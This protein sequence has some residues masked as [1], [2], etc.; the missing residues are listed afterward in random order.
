M[1]AGEGGQDPAGIDVKSVGHLVLHQS[2]TNYL[3]T[4]FFCVLRVF[5][6]PR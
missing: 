5:A 2:I 6:P 1:R 4:N 3:I